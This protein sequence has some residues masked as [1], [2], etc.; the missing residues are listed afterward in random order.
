[1]SMTLQQANQLQKLIAETHP[2]LDISIKK[3]GQGHSD[4]WVCFVNATQYY[5]WDRS[6]W[7]EY[8]DANMKRLEIFTEEGKAQ[9]QAK[10]RQSRKATKE[11]E[12]ELIA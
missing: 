9:A 3:V 10:W 12:A 8:R 11:R 7:L 2:L 4:E 5:L 6:D 1:M